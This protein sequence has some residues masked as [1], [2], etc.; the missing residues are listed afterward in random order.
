MIRVVFV[1]K[2]KE[3]WI[4]EA[5]EEYS[6]RLQRFTNFEMV[7]VKDERIL[8]KEAEKIIAA[9]GERILG[10]VKDEDFLIALDV[11]GKELGSEQFAEQLSKAVIDNKR[12]TFVVGG[13]LG[14]DRRVVD[15]ARIKL[16]MSRMTLTNQ[17]IR[18]M[19]VEQIY[20]AFTIMKGID[21]HK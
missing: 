11:E 21:Y 16:S 12:I 2:A 18:V 5:L 17:M 14:L 9:E 7:E 8:G 3:D 6:K 15:K 19:L 13:A 10:L 4:K 20:R 1:G